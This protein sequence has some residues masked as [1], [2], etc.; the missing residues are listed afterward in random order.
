LSDFKDGNGKQLRGR[1]NP[2][3]YSDIDSIDEI[4][5]RPDGSLHRHTD[6]ASHHASTQH[7]HVLKTAIVCPPDIYGRGYGPVKTDS[8]YFPVFVEEIRK[9]GYAFYCNEG[10]NV[11]GWV[12]IDDLM[13]VYV[14]LIE[15]AAAGGGGVTWGREVRAPILSLFS[16]QITLQ[17]FMR[18]ATSSQPLKK[19]RRKTSRPQR[20]R[21]YTQRMSSAPR[22]RS[23]SVKML[24][25]EC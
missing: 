6:K 3:I 22:S 9:L 23:K 7:G 19:H 2:K 24:L 12:H 4:T 5:S 21:F 15:A 16:T 8:V 10:A 18:R 1:L 11:R 17:T 14:K 25:R 20:A 13:D